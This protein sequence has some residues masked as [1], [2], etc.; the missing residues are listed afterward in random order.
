MSIGFSDIMLAIIA[1]I[2]FWAKLKGW[3]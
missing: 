1:V 3:G 2:L